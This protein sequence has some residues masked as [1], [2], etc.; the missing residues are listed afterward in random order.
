MSHRT[1]RL[2]SL[3]TAAAV[4]VLAAAPTW[5][6]PRRIH[7][8]VRTRD[9]KTGEL[10][11]TP[12][13]IDPAKTAIVI[14]DPW[15]YHWCMTWTYQTASAV[16][17]TNMIVQC[18]RKLGMRVIWAPS[19]TASMEVGRPQRERALAVPLVD[20]PKG[21]SIRI[22]FTVRGGR[23]HCGPGLSCLINYGHDGMLGGLDI[24]ADDLIVC[25]TREMYS[26]CK[27][28]GLEHLIYAGGATNICLTGKPAGLVPMARAGIR[29]MIARDLSEA[30]THYSP[31]TGYTPDN[32]NAQAVADVERAGI[33]SVNLADE[34]KKSAYW[35]ASRRV[36][37]V[38]LWPW[39]K[40]GR[41]HLF[42]RSVTVTLTTPW[43]KGAA[44]HYTTDGGEP[45][46]ASTVYDKPLKLARTTT[47]RAAAFRAGKRVSVLSDGY[48]VLLP[49][50]PPRPDVYVDGLTRLPDAYAK[51]SPVHAA[52][53]WAPKAGK[54][55]EGKPLRVRGAV[56]KHGLGMRAP[57][58]A[59]YAIKAEYDR[60]VALAGI[61]DNMLAH[62]LGR[63]LAM[64]SSVVFKVFIDGKAAAASPVMRMSAGPWRFN[65]K[66]PPGA[67]QIS[68][69]ATDAGSRNVLDLGNWVE[70]GFVVA[71]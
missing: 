29:C 60:F 33:A 8:D 37:A 48:Y 44:I 23:C 3:P 6:A 56:Y 46:S 41:P 66:I 54:S 53:I 27:A 43:I 42:A 18:A 49:P 50:R 7:L 61:D 13:K 65:V 20:V 51:V 10:A 31:A 70:A 64:H 12:T 40:A 55:F 45:S 15:N 52:C 67:R 32:G 58:N 34:M 28:L 25:G 69:S 57:G 36:D 1:H 14:V 5:A 11:T 22:P 59:R 19:D 35:D 63:S 16:Q 21:A 30:W 4:V 2:L 47:L 38:R 9:P 39:G 68:L 24:A 71:K 17:R 62:Q 26:N